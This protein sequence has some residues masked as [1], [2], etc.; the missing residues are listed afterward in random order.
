M[1]YQTAAIALVQLLGVAIEMEP[2][3]LVYRAA[4]VTKERI[5]ETKINQKS[6]CK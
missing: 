4:A 1:A 3:L 2:S 5:V 6:S